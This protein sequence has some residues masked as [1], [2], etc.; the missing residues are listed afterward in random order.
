MS[1]WESED[2]VARHCPD[3]GQDGVVA[4]EEAATDDHALGHGVE[5]RARHADDHLARAC[6]WCDGGQLNIRHPADDAD[7]KARAALVGDPDL[8]PSPTAREDEDLLAQ[9]DLG[10]DA[11]VEA[12]SLGH[13]QSIEPVLDPCRV[14]ERRRVDR[15]RARREVPHRRYRHPH[16]GRS[17]RLRECHGVHDR[18]LGD[19]HGQREHKEE[20]SK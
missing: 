20:L 2:E 4:D 8:T 17:R 5:P 13:A 14:T 11:A 6:R 7:R 1:S 15:S 18:P 10:V 19:R 16:P 12:E 9:Q 3:D